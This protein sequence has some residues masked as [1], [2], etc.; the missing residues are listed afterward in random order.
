MFRFMVEAVRNEHASTEERLG[1]I[2]RQALATDTGSLKNY[3]V[4]GNPARSA[5]PAALLQFYRRALDPEVRIRIS[6]S[7]GSVLAGDTAAAGKPVA[8]VLVG[9]L[10]PG[11]RVQVFPAA[12]PTTVFVD[13]Q[14]NAYGWAVAVVALVNV[15][16]SGA[17]AIALHRQSQLR[18]LQNSALATVAHELKTPLASMRV[19]TDTLLEMPPADAERCRGYLQLIATENDRLIRV[20]E[21][22]LTLSRFETKSDLGD[23]SLVEPASLVRAALDSMEPRFKEAGIQPETV[24]ENGLP[25]VAVNRESIIVVFVNLLDNA[26]KYSESGEPVEIRLKATGGMVQF[27]V[28]DHGIG[29]PEEAQTRVFDSFFQVDQK[30]ARTRE[31][32]GLGLHIARSIVEAHG[33]TISVRSALGKG[34]TFCVSLPATKPS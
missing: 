33:G 32:C 11:A 1:D 28:E 13:E 4:A 34:S 18:H 2:Y 27:I 25:A 15:M 9:A 8:E 5:T 21:N 29:I 12:R 19:L 22:F 6:G 10:L 30:L 3:F 17:A 23:R 14:I 24:I 31:G 20:T 16:I 7:D 26:L